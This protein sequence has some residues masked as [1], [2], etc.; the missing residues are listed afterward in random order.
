M[1]L[2]PEV[3]FVAAVDTEE[4]ELLC[5]IVKIKDEILKLTPGYREEADAFVAGLHPCSDHL[6]CPHFSR[7]IT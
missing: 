3:P 7:I 4:E 6:F 2:N 1:E 5:R